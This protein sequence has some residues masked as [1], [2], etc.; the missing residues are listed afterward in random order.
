MKIIRFFIPRIQYVLFAA[1]FWSVAAAGPV[2]L[3][4]DGD[5]PR[6]LLVGSL[7][8]ATH[9]VGLVD[10]FSFRTTGYPSTPHE[11]LSQVILS[12]ANSLMGLSGVVLL[13][14]IL[15]TIT[16]AVVYQDA[17]RRSGSLLAS[18][19]VTAIAV[20]ASLIHLIPR[21]HLFSYLLTALW[22]TVLEK[23]KQKPQFA[24]FLPFLMLI[25]VN[26]HGMFIF[27]LGIWGIYLVGSFF[28]NPSKSW[29]AQYTSKYL[30]LGGLL[31]LPMTLLSPS[32]IHIWE[33]IASLGGNAYI[34]EHISEY[35]SPD[36]QMPETWPA[37]LLLILCLIS[38]ARS[39]QKI[40]WTYIF[41]VCSFAGFALYSSRMLPQFAIITA[42]IAAQAVANWLKDDFPN[43]RLLTAETNITTINQSSNG[44][45]WVF[46]VAS[47]VV[48][49]F[50]ANVT[51]DP[52]NMGNVFDPKFFPI[53]A[54]DWLKTHPQSGHVFNEFDW[55]GYMLLELWPNQQIF[56]DGHTHIYGEKLTREYEQVITL[57]D[58]WESIFQ[59][60]NI[61]WALIRPTSAVAKALENEGWKISYQNETA[62]ILTKP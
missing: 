10:I 1:I 12:V 49:L 45:I 21:P 47:A 27:G 25:W 55:G 9:K 18:L 20:S 33:T 53:Q 24:W 3:N 26:L 17:W 41:L 2:L 34:K 50:R 48:M 58:G 44:I 62:L 22:I 32:G 42:P 30:L 31:A 43:S 46:A 8:R 38:F 13:A 14:A 4:S 7:I 28:E 60:W 51:I 16:W 52:K 35:R 23:A 29:F 6:H 37:I 56:M 40:P 59:K 36:F 39:S 19:L 61:T 15:F 54:V 11:W 5:L 57:G